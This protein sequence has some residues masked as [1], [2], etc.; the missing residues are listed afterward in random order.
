VNAL[1]QSAIE[2]GK[3]SGLLDV[4]LSG[5]MAVLRQV[6]LETYDLRGHPVDLDVAARSHVMHKSL[7]RAVSYHNQQSAPKKAYLGEEMFRK[8]GEQGKLPGSSKSLADIAF[9]SYLIPVLDPSEQPR[10][11]FLNRALKRLRSVFYKN[12]KVR[13]TTNELQEYSTKIRRF[14]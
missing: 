7:E 2:Q 4:V 10:P 6:R 5:H 9:R 12:E 8:A 3:L 14:L 1:R 11:R 13:P